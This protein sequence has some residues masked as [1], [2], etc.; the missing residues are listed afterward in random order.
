MTS[1]VAF[2]LCA[3]RFNPTLTFRLRLR[4][5]S[6]TSSS[7]ASSDSSSSSL[8]A[9][10]GSEP[11]PYGHSSF[12]RR[13]PRH[14]LPSQKRTQSTRQLAY[15]APLAASR[16]A[17]GGALRDPA[18]EVFENRGTIARPRDHWISTQPKSQKPTGRGDQVFGNRG[19]GDLDPVVTPLKENLTPRLGEE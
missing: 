7:S 3:R 15:L 2:P 9:D 14:P 8:L 13:P 16:R 17:V 18:A 11:H 19:I 4:A 12:Q 6:P 1:G 10:S 5:S